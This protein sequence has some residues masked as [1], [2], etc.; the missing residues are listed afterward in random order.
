MFEIMTFHRVQLFQSNL[1]VEEIGSLISIFAIL[2]LVLAKLPFIHHSSF[3][4]KAKYYFQLFFLISEKS[5][6]WPFWDSS[7]ACSSW[8][9]N[10]R[11]NQVFYIVWIY[12]FAIMNSN[13][14][15][16]SFSQAFSL[17]LSHC[18]F[19]PH[20]FLNRLFPHH[21]MSNL[22][23]QAISA[24]MSSRSIRKCIFQITLTSS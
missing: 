18:I 19:I 22:T 12:Q 4:L 5:P 1:W 9:V 7:F 3:I 6:L 2:Q 17:F 24:L 20:N 13:W 14:D 8:G 23:K 15:F 11:V 10:C 16:F 21:Q